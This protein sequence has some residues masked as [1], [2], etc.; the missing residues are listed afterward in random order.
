MGPSRILELHELQDSFQS[1]L[2]QANPSHIAAFFYW[3]DL[4]VAQFKV[5]GSCLATGVY[6]CQ[7]FSRWMFVNCPNLV[8][9]LN[10]AVLLYSI[11]VMCNR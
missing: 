3:L 7:L 5:F 1:L 6:S 10:D 2:L 9:V 8:V 11:K 4:Q